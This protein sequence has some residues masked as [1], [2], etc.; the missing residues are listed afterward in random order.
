MR[1]VADVPADLPVALARIVA[2]LRTTP[3]GRLGA[4]LSGAVPTRADA[5]RMLARVLV[6]AAQGIENGAAAEMPAWR[7]LP[8]LPDLS[9][10]DQVSVVAHDLVVAVAAVLDARSLV[11]T[12]DGRASLDDVLHDVAAT[13]AEVARL[14]M[15]V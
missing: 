13:V 8:Q 3:A 9:V 10:G 2:T 5:G 15:I 1:L 12:P 4:A 11:W 14:L 7:T 6:H